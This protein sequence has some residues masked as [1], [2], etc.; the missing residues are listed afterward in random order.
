M[1]PYQGSAWHRKPQVKSEK[2]RPTKEIH[3]A[4]LMKSPNMWRRNPV[5]QAH[6]GGQWDLFVFLD[7]DI[8]ILSL[9]ERGRNRKGRGSLN[10]GIA[11]RTVSCDS[12]IPGWMA[13]DWDTFLNHIDF[14]F[15]NAMVKKVE[16]KPRCLLVVPNPWNRW[17]RNGNGWPHIIYGYLKWLLFDKTVFIFFEHILKEK[18]MCVVFEE[19]MYWRK[20]SKR[21]ELKYLALFLFCAIYLFGIS[22]WLVPYLVNIWPT[23][24]KFMRECCKC[25]MWRD[26]AISINCNRSHR[27]PIIISGHR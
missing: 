8:Q 26:R 4:L 21:L 15:L 11:V 3:T 25:E 20:V 17:Q 1:A 19:S 22:H 2:S 23:R 14:F 5:I 27:P 10:Q 16:A 13:R 9:G 7:S 24:N 6:K 12:V 18:T